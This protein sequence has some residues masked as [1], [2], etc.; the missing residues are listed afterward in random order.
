[1]VRYSMPWANKFDELVMKHPL[2]PWTLIREYREYI[3]TQE[4]ELKK[5]FERSVENNRRQ[6][7]S[8]RD[9]TRNVITKVKQ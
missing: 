7:Q 9:K 4:K 6:I 3:K 2:E 8:L 1:M 5:R